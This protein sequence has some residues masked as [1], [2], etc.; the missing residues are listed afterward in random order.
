MIAEFLAMGGYGVFIWPCYFCCTDAHENLA[1]AMLV[2]ST[3]NVR[4]WEKPRLSTSLQGCQQ[5]R[6]LRLVHEGNSIMHLLLLQV[7]SLIHRS[8]TYT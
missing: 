2:R 8:P 7:L 5:E 3:V 4:Q 6:I 1:S